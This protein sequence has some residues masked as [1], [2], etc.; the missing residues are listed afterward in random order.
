M[1]LRDEFECSGE[2][3][4]LCFRIS[5]TTWPLGTFCGNY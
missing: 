2:E 3:K 5:V 1:E 4:V